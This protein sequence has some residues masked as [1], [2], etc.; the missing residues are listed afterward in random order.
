MLPWRRDAENLYT[1]M[2]FFLNGPFIEFSEFDKSLEHEWKSTE[3]FC[4]LIVTSGQPVSHI[5][6][7]GVIKTF[8]LLHLKKQK[9]RHYIYFHHYHQNSLK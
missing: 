4:L 7:D 5:V 6:K 1:D 3:R 8:C 2:K 9:I